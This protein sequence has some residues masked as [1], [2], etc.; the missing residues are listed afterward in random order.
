MGQSIGFLTY[1]YNQIVVF[2]DEKDFKE[3]VAVN[4]NMTAIIGADDYTK[5]VFPGLF[6]AG[7]K[8]NPQRDIL[9]DH[10]SATQRKQLRE[11]VLRR[12]STTKLEYPI[13]D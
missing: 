10:P 8:A 9:E 13:N 4:P 1:G 6:V 2:L 11:G 7:I 12:P 5:K 3:I